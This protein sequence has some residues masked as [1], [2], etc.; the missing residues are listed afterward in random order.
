MEQLIT[1]KEVCATLQCSEM[2]IYRAI[3]EGR[4]A[5]VKLGN[6][7]RFRPSDVAE[8]V[9]RCTSREQGEVDLT[10]TRDHRDLEGV[11]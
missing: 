1:I 11:A 10:E 2:T 5:R 9:A 8:Y 6:S 4:I 7:L 3:R